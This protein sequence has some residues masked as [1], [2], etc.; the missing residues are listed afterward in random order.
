MKR[1]S[2]VQDVADITPQEQSAVSEAGESSGVPKKDL[3]KITA[4]EAFLKRRN[5]KYI[6]MRWDDVLRLQNITG[7][8]ITNHYMLKNI[9]QNGADPIRLDAFAETYS[10]LT[11]ELDRTVLSLSMVTQSVHKQQAGF[12]QASQIHKKDNHINGQKRYCNHKRFNNS[13]MANASTSPFYPMTSCLTYRVPY[14]R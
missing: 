12:S 11:R 9:L 2:Y 8:L 4:S 7:E 10:R 14:P 1:N 13:F 6:S 3:E 5:D